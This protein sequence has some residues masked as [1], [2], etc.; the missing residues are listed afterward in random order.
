MSS[1]VIL[2]MF[3]S[4][5]HLTHVIK[6]HQNPQQIPRQTHHGTMGPHGTMGVSEFSPSSIVDRIRAQNPGEAPRAPRSKRVKAEQ[7]KRGSARKLMMNI[8]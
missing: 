8:I 4:F 2:C 6:N 3:M 1:Y 5:S 7:R